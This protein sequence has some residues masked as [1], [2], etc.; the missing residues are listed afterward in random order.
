MN[1][2]PSPA[3]D[4]SLL[5]E[6]A[7]WCM[8]LN[9]EGCSE[10]ER[11]AFQQWLK[12]DS[13][14]VREYLAMLD[15]WRLS[16]QLPRQHIAA[17]T[18]SILPS[19]PP[20]LPIRRRRRPLLRAAAAILLALPLAGYS[21]WMLGWL[22]N[23]YHRYQ[24]EQRLLQVTLPDGSDLELNLDTRLSF[25]NYRD[26]RRIEL[27][28]GEAYFHV[29]HDRDHPF[30]V[31]AGTST[32]T[33]TGTRFN[34]LRYHDNVVVTVTEGSVRVRTTPQGGDSNITAG[35]QASYRLGDA[36]PLTS[37]TD[38]SK[39]L[40]WRDGKLIL[41]DLPLAQA[42]PLINRYLDTPL[43]LADST[44]AN[45]RIGGIY[46]TRELAGIVDILPQVLPI[47][48]SK[49]SDGRLLV[50]SRYAQF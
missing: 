39:V 50:K 22:P 18:N 21:G 1:I 47:Q 9:A 12:A 24:T 16:E 23:D 31:T 4:D 7:D 42:L 33:V 45:L 8:R 30:V 49:A 15:I 44:A 40:A 20:A 32:I 26:Q 5:Q 6:A 48:I 36:Q 46:N 37:S 43:E 19:S 25:S 3:D 17:P 29:H 35:L 11:E 38:T 28:K 10:E 13:R 2:Q 27:D 41:D 14:H 34:V